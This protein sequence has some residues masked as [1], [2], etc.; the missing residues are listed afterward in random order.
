[1]YLPTPPPALDS[2]ST[3]VGGSSGQGTYTNNSNTFD[4]IAEARGMVFG[5][6]GGHL[7][8]VRIS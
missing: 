8:G 2:I 4:A 6:H 3:L 5:I 1:M 7:Y